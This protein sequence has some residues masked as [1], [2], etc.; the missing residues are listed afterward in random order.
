MPTGSDQS[1]A[2]QSDG[3]PPSM[4]ELFDRLSRYDGPD[5][6]FLV[7]LLRAQCQAADAGGGAI[8]RIPEG[9]QP[10]A[11]AIYPQPAEHATPPVWLAQAA[12]VAAK[13]IAQGSTQ[14][15]GLRGPEDLY[16]QPPRSHLALVPL[17]GGRGV[18]GLAAFLL[19]TADPA[20]LSPRLE[21]LELTVALMHLHEMRLTLHRRHSDLGRLRISMETLAAVNDHI[22]FAAAAMALCNEMA[23]RWQCDRVA[24]GVLHGR[25]VCLKAMSNTEKFS[26]KMKV[27]QD[28]EAAMEECLDQDIEIVA[29]PPKDATCV[30]RATTD[31]A[32]RQ[33]PSAIVSLP[34]RQG[35]R[36][37]GVVTAERPSDLPLEPEQIEAMRLT[38]ELCTARLMDLHTHDR[39]FGAKLAGG[40]RKGLATMVGPRHTWLKAAAILICA[41]LAFA[42]FAKGTY[43][44]EA[45]FTLQAE[46]RQIVPAPFEG[47]LES[48]NVK[49]GQEVVAGRTVL[50]AL[51]TTELREQLGAARVERDQALKSA[52][53][54]M[55]DEE[56][57]RAQIA[58]Q[59]ARKAE[60]SIHLIEGRIRQAS[61]RSLVSGTVVE[62]DLE[63]HIGR[64]VQLGEPLFHVAPLDWL[65]AELL[66]S[67]DQIADVQIAQDGQLAALGE[68]DKH[69]AFVVERINPVAEVV[70]QRNVFKVRVRLKQVRQWMRPGMTGVAKIEIDRRPYVYIWTR[71]LVNWLRMKLWL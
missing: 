21:R 38:C 68:P 25:Y 30:S 27:V 28:I 16:G 50:A 13:V 66:V 57:V 26:R 37:V 39:W 70:E 20:S 64:R 51:D 19:E 14:V 12:E 56:T 10:E 17:S 43:T 2:L 9:G 7:H 35:G 71:R 62:G 41:F 34:L 58:R 44:A 22:R 11:V 4:I 33:G 52:A 61:I 6:Q 48:V 47:I 65:R 29:P 49:V 40:L 60:A 23:S 32:R 31:L 45:K 3:R 1:P 24:F 69:V 15:R 67:E 59:E 53:E 5:E 63:R 8:L 54:A 36:P 18:R 42:I 55:R 46:R